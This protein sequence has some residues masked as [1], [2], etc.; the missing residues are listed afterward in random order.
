MRVVTYE[1]RRS[2]TIGLK[3]L[4][5]SLD[6]H[7]PGLPVD[8]FYPD[9]P[10]DT[11]DWAAQLP[12]VQLHAETNF[13]LKG[14]DVKPHLLAKALEMGATQAIWID[15]DVII[16]KDFRQ[17]LNQVPLDQI[18]VTQEWFGA[19]FQGGSYRSRAWNLPVGRELTATANTAVVRVTKQHQPLLEQWNSLLFNPEYMAAQNRPWDERP[20]HFQ[21]D[22]E[23]LSALLESTSF[24]HIPIHYLK[25][26]RDIIHCFQH[27]GYPLH[28]MLINMINR[29][30]PL[31]VHGQ[32]AK[33]WRANQ[34]FQIHLDTSPYTLCAAEY[35]AN[36]AEDM[37]WLKPKSRVGGMLRAISH[38]N[39]WTSYFPFAVY[40][41]LRHQRL[42]RTMVKH[43][44]HKP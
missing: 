7:C 41:E 43:L 22:Q 18:V 21:G 39:P 26:G 38:E 10:Q 23:V 15:T 14:Y 31:F 6:R 17:H 16:A 3:L 11:R 25:R 13:R 19:P 35:Q 27:Q 40:E 1:N 32:G 5:L 9:A 20:I 30:T 28:Q 42:L 12:S 33:P 34:G 4:L 44:L 2:D 8:V 36:T 24:A 29:N 37:P